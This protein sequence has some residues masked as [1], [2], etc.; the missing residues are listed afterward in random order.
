MKIV[1]IVYYKFPTYLNSG[2]LLGN[3]IKAWD[4]G[5]ATMRKGEIAKFVCKPEYAYGA[6]GSPP[7]IPPNATLIFEVEMIGWKAEDV[8]PKKDGSILR[9]IIE[10]G[11]GFSSPN[12]G[13]TVDI[14][15][16]GEYNGQV[17]DDRDVIFPL[18]EGKWVLIIWF[19]VIWFRICHDFFFTGSEYNICEG[20]EKALEK[21][22]IKEKSKILIKS[23]YAFGA[24][25]K[26][27]F[28]IPPNADVEYTIRL[29]NFEKVRINLLN[30]VFIYL[31]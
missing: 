9:T 14:H 30:I 8:S 31:C 16:T 7:K 26:P 6:A 18:G 5:I 23:K 11:D 17:F 1:L 21:F 10:V 13:S 4:I 24:N 22:K 3:V 12:D 20:V 27:E 29:N 25:G 19:F 2:S 28:N 15:L